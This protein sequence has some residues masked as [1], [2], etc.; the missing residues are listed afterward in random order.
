MLGP[1][2]MTWGIT[3]IFHS[4]EKFSIFYLPNLHSTNHLNF[5]F[6]NFKKSV[7]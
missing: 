3:I 6:I 5:L 7:D 1:A 4:E 2:Q